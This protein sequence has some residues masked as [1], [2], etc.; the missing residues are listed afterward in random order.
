MKKL[1]VTGL[2]ISAGIA[3][4]SL[5]A[6]AQHKPTALNHIA[7][8][9]YDLQKS[10]AF[11]RDVLQIDT[12]PEPFHDGKHTWLKVGPHAQ[13]HLIKGATEITSHDIASHL[14]FTVP[15]VD[16]FRAKLH[17]LNIPYRN[18]QGQQQEITLRVDGVKQLYLQDPDGY[19]IE[20]ND[21]KY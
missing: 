20:I 2:L 18:W 12:M 8:S 5:S 3:G 11:Y 19:W 4:L 15:S 14:C 1:I 17:K 7:V 9:V 10:T 21:D 6:Q 13:L 16:E